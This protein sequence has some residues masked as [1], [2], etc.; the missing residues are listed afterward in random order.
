MKKTR[1]TDEV[2]DIINIGTCNLHTDHGGFLSSGWDIKKL[3]KGAHPIL[4]DTP[5][6]RE[7]Y[8]NIT[9]ST[10]YPLPFVSTIWMEDKV[11]AERL[12]ELW[13][14]IAK[15]FRLGIH[16]YVIFSIHPSVCPSIY[17]A[18]YLKNRISSDHSFWYT[19]VK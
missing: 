14:N 15:I 11:I 2:N 16:L 8:F 6:R 4:H 19:C 12:T 18:P 10:E 9:G 17:H 3:L 13:P 1:H 5:A 7:D